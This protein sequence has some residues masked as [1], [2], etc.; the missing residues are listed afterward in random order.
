MARWVV[1]GAGAAG[2]VVAARLAARPDHE[3]TLLEAGA[4]AV[5]EAARG[6]SFFDSLAMAGL[7][8]PGA[9]RRG[10]GLGGSSVVNA[11]VATTGGAAQYRSWG[12]TDVAAAFARVRVP[13]EPA[14]GAERGPLD[15]AVLAAAADASAVALTRRDGRRVTAADAYLTD[16]DQPIVRT[17]SQ[18]VRIVLDGRRAVGLLLA[19]GEHVPADQVVVTAGAIGTPALL[20]ASGV[21]TPGVG[22]GLRNHPAVPVLLRLRS[23]VQVATDGLVTSTLLRRGDIQVLPMNHLGPDAP[24]LAML[25]VALMTPTGVGRVSL[26]CAAAAGVEHDGVGPEPLVEHR[27]SDRDRARLAAGV[28]IADELIEHPEL[29]ALVED[30]SIGAS[31]AG[32][33]HPTSTCAMGTV[34]DDR[35]AVNGYH[36]LHVADASV[37]PDIP[38]TNTYLPTLMLAERLVVRLAAT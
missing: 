24:G 8:F 22:M 38:A 21:D 17:G 36:G 19:G 20:L 4:A 1:V 15:R 7:T 26:D 30:V 6:A 27:L 3:V 5:P 12:W 23:G 16:G 10:R 32:I 11:M 2:C 29:A 31:P 37:F 25:L 13:S 28:M 14:D 9:F 35:A 33:F 34:V 18:A